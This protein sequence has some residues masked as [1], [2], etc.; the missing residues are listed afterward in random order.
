MTQ[1]ELYQLIGHQDIMRD[2]DVRT[3]VLDIIRKK[4]T[5]EQLLELLLEHLD[6]LDETFVRGY[7]YR[8]FS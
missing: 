4:L 7:F 5:Q 3:L 6:S 8:R 1:E 2:V